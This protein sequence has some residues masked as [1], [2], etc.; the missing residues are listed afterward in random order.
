MVGHTPVQPSRIGSDNVNY[1]K[2]VDSNMNEINVSE[3]IIV[4]AAIVFDVLMV[5]IVIV[6]S[7]L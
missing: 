4:G 6:W 1:T 2:H 5:I 3:F 7:G